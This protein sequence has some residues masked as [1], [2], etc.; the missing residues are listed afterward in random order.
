MS[1]SLP[2]RYHYMETQSPT[3]VTVTVAVA[4]K[5]SCGNFK[6]VA[7]FISLTCAL[8]DPKNVETSNVLGLITEGAVATSPRVYALVCQYHHM[9]CLSNTTTVTVTDLS[10]FILVLAN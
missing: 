4:G 6:L 3:T 10:V 5:L 2:S 7:I 9:I 1:D 8:Q